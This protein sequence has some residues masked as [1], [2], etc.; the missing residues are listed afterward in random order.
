MNWIYFAFLSAVLIGTDTIINKKILSREHAIE[1]LA[2]SSVI[3]LFLIIPMGF[4]IKV[5]NPTEYGLLFLKSF[6]AVNFFY[7]AD[8]S[9][10]H[11]KVSDYAPLMNLSPIILVAFGYLFLGEKLATV[12]LAGVTLTVAGTY[13]LELKDGFSD[14]KEPFREFKGNRELHM[15]LLGLLFAAVAATID[16][17]LLKSMRLID[18]YFWQGIFIDV[19]IFGYLFLFFDKYAGL[20]RGFKSAGWLILLSTVIYIAAD[21]SYFRAIMYPTAFIAIVIAVKRLSSFFATVVGGEI[22]H[23]DSLLRKSLA[24]AIMIAGVVLIIK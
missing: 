17:H 6:F 15:L 14:F 21:L 11:M 18:F 13:L 9:L 16:R 12:Q 8:R 19:F 5:L 24:C 1:F 22:F 4:F 7:L 20:K 2:A 23:D 10:R 3:I